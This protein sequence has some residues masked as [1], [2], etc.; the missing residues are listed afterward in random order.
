MGEKRLR[1]RWIV[2]LGN[3]LCRLLFG[4]DL[5][6]LPGLGVGATGLGVE[7][8]LDSWMCDPCTA[9]GLEGTNACF[10]ALLLLL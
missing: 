7:T 9:P 3:A 4:C 6:S 2:T 10:K 5:L 1:Q 8:G